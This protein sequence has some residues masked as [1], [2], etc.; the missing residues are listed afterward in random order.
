M[1]RVLLL[2]PPAG[3]RPILRDFTFGPTRQRGLE[4]ARAL[5][6]ADLGLRWQA[7]LPHLPRAFSFTTTL[8]LIY[9]LSGAFIDYRPI[10]YRARLGRRKIRGVRDTLRVAQT[11]V[12]VMLRFNP[13]K[14]FLA[15]AL[16]LG[17]VAGALGAAA[18]SAGSAVLGL[19][20]ALF[21]LAAALTFVAGMLAVVVA[22]SDA[23][24]GRR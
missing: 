12:E 23:T 10:A 18:L 1:A 11:L 7:V 14:L 4:Q 13:L 6:D 17:V 16:L 20:S 3:G 15:M 2:N 5:S 9:T 22:D 21:V 19:V 8:T 24:T